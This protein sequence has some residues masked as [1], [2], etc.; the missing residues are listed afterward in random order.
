M[1]SKYQ[2]L[3]QAFICTVS[4]NPPIHYTYFADEE[5]EAQGG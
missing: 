2:A 3:C 1:L 5:T 4:H